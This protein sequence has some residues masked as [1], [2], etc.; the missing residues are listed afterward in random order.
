L[1]VHLGCGDKY[2]PGFVNVDGFTDCDIQSDIKKLPFKDGEVS[3]IHLIHVFEHIHRMDCEGALKDWN[4]CLKDGGKLVIEV[5][6]LDKIAQM[7]VDGE[8]NLAFTLF[9]L[10]GDVRLN[11][12]EMLHQWC[13]S[14]KELKEVLEANGFVNIEVVEPLFHYPIR[15]IRVVAYKQEKK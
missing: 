14:K 13:W 4:R 6:C 3:E 2:W 7:I 12:P 11:R 9:G 10:F 1:R 8:K 15:D 5:P